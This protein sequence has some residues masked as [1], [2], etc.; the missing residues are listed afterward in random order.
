MS[1]GTSPYPI[2]RVAS[3]LGF[4]EGPLALPD[5]RIMFTDIGAGD[6]NILDPRS[7]TIALFAHTGG[8][9]NGVAIGP[10]GAYYVCNNGG[11]GFRKRSDGFIIPVPGSRGDDP[12][13]PCIQ[14]VTR[15]GVVT[16][17]YDGCEGQPL[18]APNDLVF[19]T[20]GGFYFTDSGRHSGRMTDLG[21][22]YYAKADGSDIVELI[23][24]A[25]AAIPLTLPNG[26]G[27]SPDGKRIYVAETATA[28]LWA[29]DIGGPGQLAVPP[30]AAT[31]NGGIFIYNVSGHARFDSLAVDSAGNICIA[32][33]LGGGISVITPDGNLDAFIPIP[34]YDPFP[35]NICFGGDNLDT[36]YLTA[37]GT[38]AIYE[39]AW[40]RKG[41][42]LNH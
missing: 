27:L 9:P 8:G 40:P 23:H 37:A 25:S 15:D 18:T 33:I 39:V 38:G 20:A 13:P 31:P 28:R 11:L 12:I 22:L 34:G 6:L 16:V 24:E 3:G 2:R 19:D 5:G 4:I 17:L 35:T 42:R 1:E 7:G 32:T 21:G 30:D 14:K 26:C 36:A 10:D 29:W 41:L